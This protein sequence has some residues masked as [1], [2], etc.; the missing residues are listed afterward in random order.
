VPQL[1]SKQCRRELTLETI[2]D[3][4]AEQSPFARALIAAGARPD[5]RGLVIRAATVSVVE[6]ATVAA[7][8]ETEGDPD[9]EPDIE[10]AAA[11]D[12]APAAPSAN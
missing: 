3:I 1:A 5:Y 9:A 8:S 10:S 7:G 11:E 2:D 12:D 4:A 6:A